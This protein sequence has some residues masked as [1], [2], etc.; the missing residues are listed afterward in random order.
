MPDERDPGLNENQRRHMLSSCQYIDRMLGEMESI[1]AAG[2]SE[3]PFDR[4]LPDGAA[5]QR[6]VGRDFIQRLRREVIN[7]LASEDLQPPPASIPATHALR[8]HL[9][10]IDVA[11]EELKPSYMRGYGDVSP[12]AAAR[13]AALVEELQGTTAKLDQYLARG[14]AGDLQTRLRRL[15]AAGR[16][17]ALI[18]MMEDI[19]DRQRLTEF[20]PALD[21]LVD[22]HEDTHFEIAVFGRVSTGKSSLLN[23]L[24]GTDV[25]P[26]GVNP[27]TAI[28]TRLLYGPVPRA[29]IEFLGGNRETIHPGRLAEFVSEEHNPGNSRRVSRVTVFVPSS[30]LHEGIV[31]VDTPGLGSLATNGAVETLAYLPRCDLGLVLIDAASTITPDDL[32]TL[33]I[34]HEAG[35][36]VL[37]LSSKADLLAPADLDRVGKYVEQQVKLQLGVRLTPRPVSIVDAW[38]A[39]L[40]EWFAREVQPLLERQED[41]RVRSI[42]RKTGALREALIATL[43]RLAG[44]AAAEESAPLAAAARLRA[45]SG[46]FERARVEGEDTLDSIP[47]TW[48]VILRHAA[49]RIVD[50]PNTLDEAGSAYTVVRLVLDQTLALSA[51]PLIKRVKDL[52]ETARRGVEDG[53][54]RSDEL[55]EDVIIRD[56]PRPDLPPLQ[57]RL[58]VGAVRLL[59]A[60]ATRRALERTLEE[61][62]GSE[63]QA[64]VASHAALLR[65]W[66][67]RA[68]QQVRDGFEAA[69]DAQRAQAMSV[70]SHAHGAVEERTIR[71]DLARLRDAGRGG[72]VVDQT[73]PLISEELPG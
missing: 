25:L 11:L 36:P 12:A 4:Y 5:A 30:R 37:L 18:R 63:I 44:R 29:V 7:A 71:A 47:L 8:T 21:I 62:A 67:R 54:D 68:L 57:L 24:L 59:G 41:L 34:L 16:D 65:Q 28:P 52:I 31:F 10:F 46:E 69:A 26:V 40:D 50:A 72:E 27:I 20:R 2:E 38:R 23:H 56:V 53:E 73:C 61:Q 13:L 51:E 43:E 35:T 49:E 45:V 6:K 3:S 66:F 42:A 58:N 22:R 9:S 33:R 15:E 14:L 39:P 1:L 70:G 64:A 48:R 32:G 19:A 55:R 60:R 17:V